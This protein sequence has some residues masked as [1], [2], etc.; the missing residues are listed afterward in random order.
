MTTTL[1][2]LLADH[3]AD[4]PAIGAPGR[5][6]LS[7]GALKA[8]AAEVR[9]SLRGFGISAGDR[10]AIVLPNGPEMA[11][12]FVTIAQA[13]VTAPLNP[14]YQQE[15]YAFYLSDLKAKALV[16]TAGYAG[17]A[18]EAAL[19]CGMVILTLQTPAGAP[20]GYFTLAGPGN[21]AGSG[22]APG[23]DATALILHTSGTT[24]RPKIVPLLQSNLA[25]S[26][27]NIAA[28]LALT[29]RDRCLNVMPLFHIHGLVAAVSASLV[30]GASVW[31][32]PGFDA[33][34]FFGWMKEA[35]PS[36]YTAVPTMHQAILSRAARNQDVI[37]AYLGVAH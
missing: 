3:D 19:A 20:A 4:A 28:S 22:G 24:S 25:A 27:R 13:A 36:W 11:A 9:A 32:A 17:P 23:P 2:A 10:V 7:H 34:K 15:E 21:V 26:A 33:L 6:W 29:P 35:R 18:L 8:L 1:A 30:A 5:D 37:D 14:G 12:A 16:V 31:C